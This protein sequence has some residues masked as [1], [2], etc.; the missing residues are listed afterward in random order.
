VSWNGFDVAGC[1]GLAHGLEKNNTLV[2][3]DISSNRIGIMAINK[4]LEGMKRNSSLEILR[5]SN[6][7]AFDIIITVIGNV[8]LSNGMVG[9]I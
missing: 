5:V 4:L 2:D 1:H 9:Y 3:L 8:Y 6:F 7:I